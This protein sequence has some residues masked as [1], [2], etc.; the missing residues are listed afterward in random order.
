MFIYKLLNQGKK[1][2]IVS[3]DLHKREY[4]SVW[5][6]YKNVKG[7][8]LCTDYPKEAEVYFNGKN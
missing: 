8:M 4:K 7:I 5:E 2:C 3:P 6:K 1:V